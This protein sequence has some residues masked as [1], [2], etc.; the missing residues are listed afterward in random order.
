MEPA[1]SYSGNQILLTTKGTSEQL[2]LED[3]SVQF[4]RQ[5]DHFAEAIRD[6]V[7]IRTPGEM[8]L[9][10]VRLMETIYT[11]AKTGTQTL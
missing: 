7:T 1:T 5:C 6:G 9:R 2:T 11:A 3:S 10:D 4:H 8:G